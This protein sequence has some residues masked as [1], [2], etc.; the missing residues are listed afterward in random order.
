MVSPVGGKPLVARFDG[1]RLSSGGGVLALRESERRLGI[2]D[3]LAARLDDP[4]LPE[5]VRHS[6]AEI[7]RFRLLVIAPGYEDGNDAD[8]DA[9][10][11]Y[12]ARTHNH[13]ASHASVPGRPSA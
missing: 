1:R 6:H 2:A 9:Q 8:A 5:A 12:P 3:R 10:R 7:I 13:P 11:P 4:R